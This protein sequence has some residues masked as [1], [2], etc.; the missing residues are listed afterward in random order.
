MME[1]LSRLIVKE[2]LKNFLRNGN[3][4]GG[5]THLSKFK[6][7]TSHWHF[8]LSVNIFDLKL[9]VTYYARVSTDNDSQYSS[10]VNQKYFFFRTKKLLL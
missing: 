8:L 1:S 4:I 10:I 6:L 2:I 7:D 3:F 9:R 5:Y